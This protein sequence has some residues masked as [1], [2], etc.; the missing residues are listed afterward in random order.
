MARSLREVMKSNGNLRYIG[1]RSVQGDFLGI[2]VVS[3]FKNRN[4]E[5]KATENAP[6]NADLFSKK[7]LGITQNN[8]LYEITYYKKT[9]EEPII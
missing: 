5:D 3:I 6:N 4:I 2:V 8:W 7:N 9:W 1:G